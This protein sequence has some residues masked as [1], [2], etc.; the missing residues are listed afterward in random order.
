MMIAKCPCYSARG[1]LLNAATLVP[2]LFLLTRNNY[3]DDLVSLCIANQLFNVDDNKYVV[4]M[5]K[6]I[7]FNNDKV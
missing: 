3:I 2:V 1:K 6:T 4:S 5:Y 7:S